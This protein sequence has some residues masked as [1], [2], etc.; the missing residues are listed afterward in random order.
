MNL[1]SRIRRGFRGGM[2]PVATHNSSPPPWWILGLM[3]VFALQPRGILMANDTNPGAEGTDITAGVAGG[4][5]DENRIDAGG[6]VF[7]P[8]FTINGGIE[9][10]AIYLSP[11]D[12]GDAACED[13]SDFYLSTAELILRA[14]FTEWIKAKAVVT[15]EDIG[16][17]DE[18]G[19][20][21]ADDA[22][23]TMETPWAPLYLALGKTGMPFGVFED[24]LIE[25][26]LT[27]ELY[28]VDQWGATLGFAPDY[29]R[30]E[31]SLSVYRNP[32]I[33]E[34]LEDFNTHEARADAPEYGK[35]E[36]FI[37]KVSLVPM[38]EMLALSV[39]YDNEP[40]DGTRNQSLGGALTL[41]VE[42]FILDLEYIT[43]LTREKGEDK[44]ENL[45]SAAVAGLALELL[46][47]LQLAA[48]YEVFRD[49]NR[50]DRDEVLKDQWVGGCNIALSEYL[51]WPLADDITLTF[52][53][54]HSR[55]EKEVDSA[56][57]DSQDMAQV[58]L[59]LEF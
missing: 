37:A 32:Q 45:E 17:H 7:E 54:R 46:E 14:F 44:K 51:D 5:A 11:D 3:L 1:R 28:E 35:F 20:L 50:E 13:S 58:Q 27:E 52:E 55:F 15:A 10:N 41:L 39:F 43:A 30:L 57:A 2:S 26:T 34:N 33:M 23:L 40:G 53:Y 8:R 25:G 22:L 36:S 49:D 47:S 16:R 42:P 38:E 9:L 56:A 59:T 29:H 12:V 19:R 6:T 24:H 4:T 18:S 48:R 21:R 31:V